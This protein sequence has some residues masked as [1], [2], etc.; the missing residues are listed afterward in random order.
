MCNIIKMTYDSVGFLKI[1]PSKWSL[2]NSYYL[3][4]SGKL[5]GILNTCVGHTASLCLLCLD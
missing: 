2:S 4:T 5:L 3:L 1:D